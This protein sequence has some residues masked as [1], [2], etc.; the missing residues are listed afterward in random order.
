V[1]LRLLAVSGAG[2]QLGTRA[3]SGVTKVDRA[4]PTSPAATPV[5]TPVA[6]PA[7]RARQLCRLSPSSAPIGRSACVYWRPE[8]AARIGGRIWWP[9]LAA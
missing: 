3:R 7:D 9:D 1:L 2:E 4:V 6:T 5:A 8:S